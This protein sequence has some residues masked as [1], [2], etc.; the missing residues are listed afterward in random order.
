MNRTD[1]LV[2]DTSHQGNEYL[3]RFSESIET[4]KGIFVRCILDLDQFQNVIGVEILGLRRIVGQDCLEFIDQLIQ[5]PNELYR[6]SYDAE[7]D[8]FYLKLAK[9]RSFDQKSVDG[10]ILVGENGQVVALK[11]KME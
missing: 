2:I 11:V 4:A 6:I 10:E 1:Y 5:S 3:I 9:E 8:S 7:S